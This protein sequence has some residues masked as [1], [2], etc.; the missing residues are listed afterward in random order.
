MNI[1]DCF[2]CNANSCSPLLQFI[3][4]SFPKKN[5][6]PKIVRANFFSSICKYGCRVPVCRDNI[7][8]ENYHSSDEQ[9]HALPSSSYLSVL[10]KISRTLLLKKIL[11]PTI[12]RTNFF[13]FFNLQVWLPGAG[14]PTVLEEK[15]TIHH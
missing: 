11:T 10:I 4:H 1:P 15:S 9:I 13:F 7:G 12:F 3:R 5:L 14:V 6:T 8:R 2:V